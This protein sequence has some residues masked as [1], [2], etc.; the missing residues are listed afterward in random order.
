MI[1]EVVEAFSTQQALPDLP[2]PSDRT[3]TGKAFHAVK[4]VSILAGRL[5]KAHRERLYQMALEPRGGIAPDWYR[6][7]VFAD[8]LVELPLEARTNLMLEV[9][10]DAL[11]AWLSRTYREPRAAYQRCADD[12]SGRNSNCH[13]F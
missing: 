11:S 1:Y 10:I 13:E 12:P 8:T 2:T 7:F 9:D 5:A 4:A 6:D 3:D